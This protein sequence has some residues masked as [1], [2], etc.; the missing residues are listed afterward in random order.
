M[1][2]QFW[3]CL[4]FI[5]LLVVLFWDRILAF[6]IKRVMKI[7]MRETT[8]N[9]LMNQPAI[10]GFLASKQIRELMADV[11]KATIPP[12]VQAMKIGDSLVVKYSYAGKNYEIQIPIQGPK[13]NWTKVEE[14]I[15]T[16]VNDITKEAEKWAGPNK[17]FPV[18]TKFII[19]DASATVKVTWPDREKRFR[20][21]MIN[22]T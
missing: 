10:K 9:N 18:H 7:T 13:A 11:A 19:S 3:T 21:T 8:I 4:G 1:S 15:G 22:W 5:V 14:L 17:S 2:I 12:N 20:D 6:I 16:R